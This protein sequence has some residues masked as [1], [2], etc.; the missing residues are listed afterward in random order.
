MQ[1][2]DAEKAVT[3]TVYILTYKASSAL[4]AMIRTIFKLADAPASVVDFV[5]TL[6]RIH[7]F[8]I[9]REMRPK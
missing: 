3:K 4:H 5:K 7:K 6:K 9:I 2:S 8:Q 1:L